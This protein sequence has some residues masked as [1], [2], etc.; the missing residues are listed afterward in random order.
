MLPFL[1][2]CMG[3]SVKSLIYPAPGVRV[4][5][6]P[7][8]F[9]EVLLE[10]GG[11]IQVVGWHHARQ[12]PK[13]R[14]VLVFFHGNGENL[15]TLK[16]G[17][18]YG[19]FAALDAPV[20]VL[21]YPGYGRSGGQPSE[22]SLKRA[23]EAAMKWVGSRYPERRLVVCGWSL[24]AAL[25]VHLAATH[26]DEV[27]GMVAMSPW[28]SLSEVATKHFPDWVV[29]L[30]LRE[31]YDSLAIAG[32]I[33]SPSLVIHGASDNIIAASQGERLAASLSKAKWILVP[34]AAHNDLLGFPSV[35]QEID[36]FVAGLSTT[37]PL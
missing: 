28:T 31:S 35:W 3:C 11:G 13:G 15:E 19:R 37:R 20:L 36:N 25:A 27:D 10:I 1:L 14:P 34:G 8:T 18:T 12:E 21:D 32:R 22:Q 5:A 7:P 4:D 26:P 29:S 6:P 24:G 30:G 33:T 17:G 2:L 9:E 16:W 23:S